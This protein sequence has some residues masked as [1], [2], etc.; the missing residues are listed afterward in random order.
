MSRYKNIFGMRKIVLNLIMFLTILLASLSFVLA[1]DSYKWEPVFKI[2]NYTYNKTNKVY[3]SE[4]YWSAI[5]LWN[6][7]ILTNNHVVEDE[8][9]E[10]TWFYEICE[11]KDFTKNPICF[12]SAKLLYV[13]KTKDLAFL[14]LEKL[15][16]LDKK[17]TFSDKEIS[18]W[19]K[20]ETYGY[21]SNG[22]ETITFTSWKISW[23]DSGRYKIDASVDSWS[24]G[25]WAFD[26]D[27][28]LVW[29]MTSVVS[30]YTTLWYLVPITDVK[31]F[32]LKKWNITTFSNF[33]TAN[34]KNF[35][36]KYQKRI[37]SNSIS[38]DYIDINNISKYG[39]RISENIFDDNDYMQKYYLTSKSWNTSIEI[40]NVKKNINN[41]A[42]SIEDRNKT[43]RSYWIS[44]ITQSIYVNWVSYIY[45]Y[46]IN[47]TNW[48]LEIFLKSS[49]SDSRI[50]LYWNIANKKEL[51]SALLL[52]FNN[53]KYKKS[54]KIEENIRLAWIQ[55]NKKSDF[56]IYKYA[57]WSIHWEKSDIINN[58]SLVTLDISVTEVDDEKL[59][60]LEINKSYG[61][62]KYSNINKW[63]VIDK[64][65]IFFYLV[66][67]QDFYTRYNF[68][69]ILKYNGKNYLYNIMIDSIW[70]E[71]E[72]Y[73]HY[74][75][76]SNW[77]IKNSPLHSKTSK[78]I[79]NLFDNIIFYWKPYF[80][81]SEVLKLKKT[82][83]YIT[84]IESLHL[85]SSSKS[86]S[87][88]KSKISKKEALEFIESIYGS[89]LSF[90]NIEKKDSLEYKYNKSYNL[91]SKSTNWKKYIKK[92]EEFIPKL[93]TEKLKKVLL[94]LEKL[95]LDN[96]K[97]K[98]YRLILEYIKYKI[99]IEVKSRN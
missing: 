8:K 24:S 9:G 64:W 53:S 94:K 68:S 97:L 78:I 47:K 57:Y 25:W 56:N 77:K 26:K 67:R 35:L 76:D 80:N 28:K 51:K 62:S 71:K 72:N 44:E 7:I 58:E 81:E 70:E 2:Y 36:N 88:K 42:S 27:W 61:V 75:Y 43:I 13:D 84:W 87:N 6:N 17:I 5:Y 48:D 20:I 31:E 12:T 59:D 82:W 40:Y 93:K 83:N 3:Y 14:I 29:V 32:L 34:F 69:T 38:T 50:K 86:Y 37:N 18:I 41:L 73:V 74:T 85:Y 4:S 33:N 54:L 16:N 99:L 46:T 89:K 96:P 45:G 30:G 92:I 21:P 79:L 66:E 15:P 95:N 10:Y 19:D 23:F 63:I 91:L 11:T 65:K 90:S 60:L 55:I 1:S 39:F 52:I 49:F 22:W 98:K